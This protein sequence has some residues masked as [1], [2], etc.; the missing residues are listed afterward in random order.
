MRVEPE[1]TINPANE[2]I[3]KQTKERQERFKQWK[4]Q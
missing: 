1:K 2:K 4:K 3:I